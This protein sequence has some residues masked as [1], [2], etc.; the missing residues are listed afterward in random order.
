M[1]PNRRIE[2][3]KLTA[4]TAAGLASERQ[5]GFT[6]LLLFL[7]FP[8]LFTEAKHLTDLRIRS[9]TRSAKMQ[10]TPGWFCIL[11]THGHPP[12]KEKANLPPI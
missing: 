2:R 11:Y 4:N 10:T 5:P 3:S 1:P 6:S 8:T 7:I 12:P 9:I